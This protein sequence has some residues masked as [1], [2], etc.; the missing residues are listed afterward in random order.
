VP[1]LVYFHENQVTYPVRSEVERDYTYAFINM[2]TALAATRV[3][4][5]TEYHR[6]TFLQALDQLLRRM[7]DHQPLDALDQ[8]KAKS[9][10]RPLG[11]D[12]FPE[13]RDRA[14]GPMRILWAA[15]WE[16]DKDP[17]TFFRAVELLAKQGVDFR[18]SVIGQE[19]R[20]ALEAF[21]EARSAFAHHIDRWGYQETRSAYEEAL[22]EADVVV[23]T[24]QHEFFGISM[25]EA[26]AAGAFPVAPKGLSYPEILGAEVNPDFFYDGGVKE[27]ALRLK[28]LAT[29]IS[30]GD[31]WDGN[32]NRG[33][34]RVS[35]FLW[36]TLASELDDAL[37]QIASGI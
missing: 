8:I 14:P 28:E 10:I 34:E 6:T 2:T 19:F 29:R 26:V 20:Y 13:R 3:W 25:V 5:N 31:L 35:R 15:R 4:F 33:R 32:P 21:A 18:L 1:L 17:G 7:P 12:T 27:L 16:Y 37:D 11:I 30:R 24:A 9:E 23:S 36:T 22:L